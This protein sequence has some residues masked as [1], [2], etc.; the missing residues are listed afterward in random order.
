MIR[1][2]YVA[3]L[4]A[5]LIAFSGLGLAFAVQGLLMSPGSG[6]GEVALAAGALLAGVILLVSTLRARRRDESSESDESL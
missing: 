5:M 3:T 1:N 2:R 6:Y 4:A